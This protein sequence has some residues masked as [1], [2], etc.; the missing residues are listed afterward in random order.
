MSSINTNNIFLV[1]GS[2]KHRITLKY[3]DRNFIAEE[4]VKCLYDIINQS[5]KNVRNQP[6]SCFN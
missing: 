4:C 5:N 6:K 1:V 3:R 2:T